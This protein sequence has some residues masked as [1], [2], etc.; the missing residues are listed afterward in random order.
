MLEIPITP[1]SGDL[2]FS[3]SLENVFCSFRLMWNTK[4]E[5]WMVNTY[6][7]PETGLV[8]HGLKIIPNY[9]FLATYGPSFPGQIIPLK[10]GNDTE[11]E[12][13]FSNFG[14]GWRLIYLNEEE[15]AL[16]SELRG[17]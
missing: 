1:L 9:P 11:E 16:W 2:S 8:L 10:F 15:F 13:T 6:E 7:E 12:I 3:V 14:T 17:F 5:Y 4:T